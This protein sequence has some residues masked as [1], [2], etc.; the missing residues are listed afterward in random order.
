MKITL[1]LE[2]VAKHPPTQEQPIEIWDLKSND[3]RFY[4]FK[5]DPISS[6]ADSSWH[7]IQ[8][9]ETPVDNLSPSPD[10]VIKVNL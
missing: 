10:C 5:G 3:A 2:I 7:H 1:E 8:N 6:L 4:L 9:V